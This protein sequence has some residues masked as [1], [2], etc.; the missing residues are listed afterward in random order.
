MDER[1][2]YEDL[3]DSS[4]RSVIHYVHG[5]TKLYCSSLY[6]TESFFPTPMKMCLPDLFIA[7][8]RVVIMRPGT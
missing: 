5:R 8:G 1:G 4:R 7:Q 2:G 6:E 3:H